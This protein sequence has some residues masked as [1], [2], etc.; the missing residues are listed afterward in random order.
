MLRKAFLIALTTLTASMLLSCGSDDSKTTQGYIEGRYT[1]LA[2]SVSGHL[3]ERLVTRGQQV[4]I[5]NKLYVLDPLP[6]SAE[7]DQAQKN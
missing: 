3:E 1:Y 6:E 5:G 7:L 2:S 4:T